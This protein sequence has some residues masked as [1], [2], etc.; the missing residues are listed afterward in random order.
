MLYLAH[1]VHSPLSLLAVTHYTI[2]GILWIPKATVGHR[3]WERS[4]HRWV[5]LPQGMCS[6]GEEREKL[7][8]NFWS[9]G[10]Q[11]CSSTTREA[12]ASP[13]RGSSAPTTQSWTRSNGYSLPSFPLSLFFF[14][15]FC[16][17]CYCILFL[18]LFLLF[19]LTIDFRMLW[20][21]SSKKILSWRT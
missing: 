15:F 4:R 11:E 10:P 13:P 3:L 18:F 17:F 8:Y 21:S 1:A 7:K 20:R 16:L 14:F 19:V 2:L 6:E 12:T 9:G 5:P